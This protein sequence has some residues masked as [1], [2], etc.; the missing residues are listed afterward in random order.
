MAAKFLVQTDLT[1]PNV[2]VLLISGNS[3]GIGRSGAWRWRRVSA[4]IAPIVADFSRSMVDLS[5]WCDFF[6]IRWLETEDLKLEGMAVRQCVKW[7]LLRLSRACQLGTK[8]WSVWS[9]WRK[10]SEIFF[11]FLFFF[12]GRKRKDGI[13]FGAEAMWENLAMDQWTWVLEWLWYH[14][15]NLNL[16][17]IIMEINI[18]EIERGREWRLGFFTWF[19]YVSLRP[20]DVANGLHLY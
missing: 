13:Y 5:I 14:V 18:I 7:R 17:E 11:F 10:N 9:D 16:I 15:K 6:L 8:D 12:L 1:T 2:M 3:A 19:G 20:Q 4:P